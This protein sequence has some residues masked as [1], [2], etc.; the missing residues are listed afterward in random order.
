MKKTECQN[1]LE[2]NSKNKT[3]LDLFTT[4]YSFTLKNLFKPIMRDY[5]IRISAET[6]PKI[7]YE[8]HSLEN[9]KAQY[10]LI[11]VPENLLWMDQTP[12]NLEGLGWWIVQNKLNE[13]KVL[14]NPQQHL[15]FESIVMWIQ[16]AFFYYLQ[17]KESVDYEY[18]MAGLSWFTEHHPMEYRI[19]FYW[20]HLEKS[21]LRQLEMRQVL[22]DD[23]S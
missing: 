7:R 10:D 3:R 4:T 21:H 23:C 9:F 1:R 17:P 5:K 19:L 14:L 2:S 13:M 22:S 20:N 6:Y 8:L 18:A 15:A 12:E 11:D 16:R